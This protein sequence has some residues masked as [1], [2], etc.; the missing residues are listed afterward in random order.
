SE[1][2]CSALAGMDCV[3]SDSRWEIGRTWRRSASREALLMGTSPLRT[4]IVDQDAWP[5]LGWAAR[6][7][8]CGAAYKMP[9]TARSSHEQSR[10]P[11]ARDERWLDIPGSGRG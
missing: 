7:D 3:M 10:L 9:E 6:H 5:W 2:S 1:R 11:G 8:S 4:S